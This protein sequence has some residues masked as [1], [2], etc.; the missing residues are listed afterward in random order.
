MYDVLIV[1]VYLKNVGKIY[2]ARSVLVALKLIAVVG[3]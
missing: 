3:I 1:V 2:L